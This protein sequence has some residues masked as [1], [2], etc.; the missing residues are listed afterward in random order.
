MDELGETALGLTSNPA[1]GTPPV[2]GYEFTIANGQVTG[3]QFVNGTHTFNLNLPASATFSVGTN[4]ATVTETLTGTKATETIQFAVDPNHAGMYQIA[5]ETETV[6]TPSI[7]G[8]SGQVHGYT[9]TLTN[10]AVTGMQAVNGTHSFNLMIQPNAQ[11]SIGNNTITETLTRGNQLET[12]TY[13]AP[14]GGSTY[15]LASDATS[16]VYAGTATTALSIEPFDRDKFTFDGSGTVTQIQAVRADG[17]TVTLTP[18]ANVTFTQLA[19]G[20]VVET[21]THGSNS[22]YE[23]YH[24]GNGDGIYTAVAHGHGTTVDL[25]GLKAQITAAIDATL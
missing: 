3:M 15:A 16:F 21:V 12:L 11:F 4:P 22:A 9:F 17:S 19:P 23:V 6:T 14:G 25:V 8:S 18:N 5:S 2:R 7:T 20:F 13:V 24:D 1:T 10:G